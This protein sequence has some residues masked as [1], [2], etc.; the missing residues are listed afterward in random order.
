MWKHYGGDF[1]QIAGSRR[2]NRAMMRKATLG[3]FATPHSQW[4]LS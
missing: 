2:K 4:R 1:A 3:I